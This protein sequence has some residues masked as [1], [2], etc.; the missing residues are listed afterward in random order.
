MLLLLLARRRNGVSK[1]KEEDDVRRA[2]LD[3]SGRACRAGSA[4][5]T[6][7]NEIGSAVSERGRAGF[8]PFSREVA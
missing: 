8:S 7:M 3:L 6:A 4:F 5:I 2:K 1:K